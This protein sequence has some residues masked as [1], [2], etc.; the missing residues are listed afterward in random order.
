MWSYKKFPYLV[1]YYSHLIRRKFIPT[2]GSRSGGTSDS[3]FS[4]AIASR[5]R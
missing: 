4:Y 2:F 1:D 3:I 5:G